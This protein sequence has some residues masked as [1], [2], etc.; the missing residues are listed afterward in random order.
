MLRIFAASS[1]LMISLGNAAQALDDGTYEI[2]VEGGG[3]GEIS[4][5][6][7][8]FSI[9]IA[10]AGC[11][12]SGSGSIFRQPNRTSWMAQLTDDAYE[13]I[14]FISGNENGFYEAQGC[15]YFHGFGC[16]FNGDII[17]RMPRQEP[18]AQTASVEGRQTAI[19]DLPGI[20]N[21]ADDQYCSASG[22]TF[23]EEFVEGITGDLF[24]EFTS[25][26]PGVDNLLNVQAACYTGINTEPDRTAMQFLVY[27]GVMFWASDYL[28]PEQAGN[29]TLY[30]CTR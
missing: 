15:S 10:T 24:C 27:D 8:A 26:E 12:G 4:V 7:D 30:R 28:F 1:L 23:T 6:D 29:T 25:S 22:W 11:V 16:G 21:I 14:C 9:S 20:W 19:S 18:P 2:A 17:A 5:E 13:G 3:E